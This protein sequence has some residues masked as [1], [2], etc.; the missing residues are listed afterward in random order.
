MAPCAGSRV[1]GMD[2]KTKAWGNRGGNT[3]TTLRRKSRAGDPMATY[4]RLPADLRAWLAQ[5]ALPWSP[6]SACRVWRSALRKF[7]NDTSAAK[8]YL[9]QLEQNMLSRDA[10]NTGG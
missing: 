7:A 5:A 4:D 3:R 8:A 6:H 10:E 1:I 9:N 2:V